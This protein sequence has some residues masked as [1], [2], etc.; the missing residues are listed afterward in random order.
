[1][2]ITLTAGMSNIVIQYRPLIREPGAVNVWSASVGKTA[3]ALN[4]RWPGAD[5]VEW[6]L[7]AASGPTATAALG[8]LLSVAIQVWVASECR[9]NPG[10]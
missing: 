9:G 8:R 7:L 10:N 4:G 3:S 5:Q 2:P 1:M 6:P